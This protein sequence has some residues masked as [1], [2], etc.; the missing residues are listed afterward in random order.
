MILERVIRDLIVAACVCVCVCVFLALSLSVPVPV[1]NARVS[2]VFVV[3]FFFIHGPNYVF[4]ISIFS[5][6]VH[7]VEFMA[8]G[9]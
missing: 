5:Y 7:G 4:S 3:D 8:G 2:C 6:L 1:F 9:L